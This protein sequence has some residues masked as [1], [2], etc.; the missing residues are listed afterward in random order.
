MPN[1]VNITPNG[2]VTK[3]I[4]EEG[5]GDQPVR[6]Q[7]VKVHYVGKL[8]Q[9]GTQFDST[10][11]QQR[12][13]EFTVGEDV[14]EGWSLGV[15]TMKVG[16]KAKFII[17]PEYAYGNKG[18]PPKIPPNATL[19]FEIE[20][21]EIVLEDAEAV[22]QAEAL[23]TEAGEAFKTGDFKKSNSLYR[24]AL[25]LVDEKWTDEAEKMKVRL[26]RNIS[27]TYGKLEKWQR[28]V[29]YAD[30][31]LQKEKTDPRALLRKC[32]GHLRLGE[33]ELARKALNSG[34]AITNNGP[35]FLALK[36]EVEELERKERQRQTDFFKK[37]LK[38]D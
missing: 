33:V 1:L 18:S 22:A 32:E 23:C 5:Y 2:Q 3:E 31:V 34:L 7:K 11:S 4:L 29:D 27:I 13:F 16:E 9:D 28:S 35:P 8:E 24:R 30:K 25:N 14:I 20:L 12:P 19:I 17:A 21:L 37:L 6:G 15:V 26:N 36:P 38:K 10:R